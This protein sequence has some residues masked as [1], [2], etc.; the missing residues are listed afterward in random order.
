[1][2]TKR[3]QAEELI[4]K[5]LDTL[6]PQEYNSS[7]Y[8]AMFAEMTDSQFLEFCKRNLPIRFHT[9]PF[10]IEPKM[11]DIEAALKILGVP[12]L[13]KVALPYLYID[14]DGNPVWSKEALVIYIHLKKMKQFITKKNSTPTG[15]DNRD[16]KTGLLVSF[17]KGGKTSDRE[18]EALAVMGLDET[19]KEL[20]TWR[21]DYMDAKSTAYQVISTLGR[22]SEEDVSLEETDSIAK[23]TL[24]AY[25]TSALINT[26]ILNEDYLLPKTLADRHRKIV[27]ET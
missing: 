6:D 16:M 13:E 5:V 26:N 12:L 17:D 8:K 1:M 4:Y 10:V 20:S 23:N 2:N 9:K 21:A 19:M 24:N 25:L 7:Y 27:R 15:I 14:K 11:Y 3:Q 22:I 18:M